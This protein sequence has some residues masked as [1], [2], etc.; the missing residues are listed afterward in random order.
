MLYLGPKEAKKK[1]A[2]QRHNS[3]P[4][5]LVC[6]YDHQSPEDESIHQLYEKFQKG[7]VELEQLDQQVKS[8]A[9]AQKTK[10]LDTLWK[11]DLESKKKMAEEVNIRKDKRKSSSKKDTAD[12]ETS[13]TEAPSWKEILEDDDQKSKSLLSEKIK[14][15]EAIVNKNQ[16]MSSTSKN[17]NKE[18]ENKPKVMTQKKLKMTQESETKNQ[19]YYDKSK[20]VKGKSIFSIHCMQQLD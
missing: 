4:L 9:R 20:I 14:Q 8:K 13:E 12:E 6:E 1:S 15:T 17:L 2:G 5:C 16:A 11:M 10:V 18:H 3:Y 19:L 7:A